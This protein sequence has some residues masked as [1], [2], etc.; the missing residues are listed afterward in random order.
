LSEEVEAASAQED[1]EMVQRGERKR[2]RVENGRVQGL[3]EGNRGRKIVVLNDPGKRKKW[4]RVSRFPR[5]KLNVSPSSGT[6][7]R[8]EAAA[9]EDEGGF[10]LS[11]SFFFFLPPLSSLVLSFPG[12][13]KAGTIQAHSIA[14]IGQEWSGPFFSFITVRHIGKQAPG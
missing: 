13:D 10:D 1:A 14:S 5:Q 8:G 4:Q 12:Q 2:E 3:G 9:W 6:G 7:V 11:S